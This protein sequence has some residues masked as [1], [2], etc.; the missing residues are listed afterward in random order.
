MASVFK[1]ITKT[2]PRVSS[3]KK[4][5]QLTT[6]DV[7]SNEPPLT[8]GNTYANNTVLKTQIQ[9][10][11]ST[12]PSLNPI[13]ENANYQSIIATFNNSISDKVLNFWWLLNLQADYFVNRFQVKTGSALL[14]QAIYLCFRI[15]FLFGNCGIYR[16]GNTFIP[17]YEIKSTR[18]AS[19][20]ITEIIASSAYDIIS[21]A[22]T[23]DYS[24][25]FEIGKGSN[26]IKIVGDDLVNNY[27]RLPLTSIGVGAIVLFLPFIKSQEQI[28]KKI[29][30]Y[31]L[32]FTKKIIYEI[33]DPATT[34]IELDLFFDSNIPIL[35]KIGGLGANGSGFQVDGVG[36]TSDVKNIMDYYDFFVET[37]YHL[38]GR[39]FN[40]D[41]KKER[42]ITSE[43]D[44]S[45]DNFDILEN[46]DNI[47]KTDFLN[48]LKEISGI[49]WENLAEKKQEKNADL[50]KEFND[51]I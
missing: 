32:I 21:Q 18:N 50:T 45:Q 27:A 17:V 22:S 4:E 26:R 3:E 15:H 46:E 11:E 5:K 1:R 28:L 12:I 40:I 51:E 47:L 31:S 41:S 49:D 2:K 43:I 38:L 35:L 8:G 19:G 36:D 48:K 30:M 42:N 29:Y 7:F 23:F 33:A 10:D 14:N 16:S 34:K 24:K 25:K 44:A 13:N 9:I 20:I 6:A 37:N 39:R